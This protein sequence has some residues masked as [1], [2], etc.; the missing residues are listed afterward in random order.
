M[1]D[2]IRAFLRGLDGPIILWLISKGHPMHGYELLKE[3]ERLTGQ[4]L[5]LS[6]LYTL[7]YRLENDGLIT[8]E[9]VEKG[10]R[11]LKRYYLTEKGK[12]LLVKVFDLFKMPIGKV[13]IDLLN[14]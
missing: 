10:R 7:L 4:R 12:A 9:W 2:V 11:E 6:T 1:V 14:E 5:K 3:I 13:V 8:G